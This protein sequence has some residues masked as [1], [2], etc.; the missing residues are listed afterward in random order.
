MRDIRTIPKEILATGTDNITRDTGSILYFILEN[1]LFGHDFISENGS[2]FITEEVFD[3]LCARARVFADHSG[4]N[5][6]E[7]ILFLTERLQASLPLTASRLETF[8]PEC[9]ILPRVRYRLLDWAVFALDKEAHLLTSDE[10]GALVR[11]MDHNASLEAVRAFCGFLEWMRIKYRDTRYAVTAIPPARRSTSTAGQAYGIATV[12]SLYYYLF[13]E[14]A[15]RQ[16]GLVRRA[17]ESEDSAHAWTYLSIHLV[18]ALRDTDLARLLHPV[19][20]DPPAEVLEKIYAGTY[21]DTV[22]AAAVRST[23]KRLGYIHMMPNKTRNCQAVP[24]L[25]LVI[26]QSLEPHFGRLFMACEAHLRL[27][28]RPADSPLFR[29]VTAYNK[30]CASLG[31][32][33]GSLF[34]ERDAS[35]VALAK[36]YLQCLE[37]AGGSSSA[38][39]SLSAVHGYMLASMARSH[40]GGPAGF[41]ET[42]AAYLK[43]S[44]L[45]IISPEQTARELFDRGILSCLPSMLLDLV[46]DGAYKRLDFSQQEPWPVPPGCGKHHASYA[47]GQASQPGSP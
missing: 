24:E 23:M 16:E 30:L 40:K 37:T 14:D 43:D 12:A 28:G 31:N 3:D 2:L 44:G 19:L 27:S 7:K 15:V 33:I 6:E 1:N 4:K 29:K 35:P 36:S 34:K 25:V 38:D 39:K 42:T 10:A 20:P 32:N 13:C 8:F 17:C 45:G 47:P 5:A 46:T 22:Y 9:G 18:S 11:Q 21:E 26:P 41:A